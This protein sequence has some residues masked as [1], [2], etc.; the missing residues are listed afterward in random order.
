MR[1]CKFRSANHIEGKTISNDLEKRIEEF[2]VKGLLRVDK[3][4]RTYAPDDQK[5]E[6]HKRPHIEAV[7]GFLKTQ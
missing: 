5:E 6:Y 7:Y 3:K 4:F 2:G 1:T